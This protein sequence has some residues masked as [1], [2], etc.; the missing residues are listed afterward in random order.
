MATGMFRSPN[1]PQPSASYE[2]L[3]EVAEVAARKEM[4]PEEA[5]HKPG[6]NRREASEI[7][8]ERC[9][10]ISQPEKRLRPQK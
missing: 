1:G 4:A 8:D 7:R 2:A 10:E 5:D 9:R 6:G 3:A